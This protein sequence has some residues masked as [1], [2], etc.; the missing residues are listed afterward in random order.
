MKNIKKIISVLSAAAL[1]CAMIACGGTTETPHTHTYSDDYAYNDTYHY[2]ETTCGHAVAPEERDGYAKH[3]LVNGVCSVCNYVQPLTLNEFVTNHK[4]TAIDFVTN[5]IRPS[6]VAEN[7]VKAEQ[8][9]IEGNSDNELSEINIVWTYTVNESDR[10]TQ[11]ANVTLS[12]PI[13]FRYIANDNYT[14]NSSELDIDRTDIFEFDARINYNKQNIA[15]ALY[16]KAEL[17]ADVKLYT[18][19]D[20]GDVSYRSFDLLGQAD[21]KIS[22]KRINVL[23]GDGSDDTLLKNINRPFTTI[24]T[25][26]EYEIKGTKVYESAYAL[27]DLGAEQDPD[28]IVPDDDDDDEPEEPEQPITNAEIIEALNEHCLNTL[29]ENSFTFEANTALIENDAWYINTDTD[30]KI[31][32]AEYVFIYKRTETVA[33]FTIGKIEF[34]SAISAQDLKNGNI[35]NPTY[36]RPYRFDYNPT[37]QETRAALTNAICDKFFGE[38]EGATRFIVDKGTVGGAYRSFLILEIDDSTIKEAAVSL[39]TCSSDEEYINNISSLQSTSQSSYI[40]SGVKVEN[41]DSPFAAD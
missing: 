30:D 5:E 9:Y 7:Q 10:K 3:T 6:V 8:W 21:N 16:E 37:I 27:E 32:I 31:T 15:A 17:T 26:N 33:Y 40:I 20:S 22:V 18:E 38:N 25:A 36:S 28:P 23:K 34:T 35:G 4:S 41:N 2:H 12:D 19:I 39:L 29:L 14:L 13:P 1:G 24:S 11:W